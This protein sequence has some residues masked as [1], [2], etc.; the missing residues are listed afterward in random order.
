MEFEENKPTSDADRRLAEAKK[1]T[2]LPVH[3][4]VAP[5][6][7]H[8]SEIAAH[9][10]NEPAIANISNDT[11]DS[12]SFMQPATG[13]L[14]NEQPTRPQAYKLIIG[15]IAGAALFTGLAVVALLK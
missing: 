13:F 7:P 2:L 9:H 4:D 10:L 12:T 1:L 3:T 5:D 8:D 15:I 6:A 14:G 11:E